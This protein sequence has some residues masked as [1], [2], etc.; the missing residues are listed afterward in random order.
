MQYARG[1]A[2]TLKGITDYT[3]KSPNNAD[4]TLAVKRK[5]GELGTTYGFSTCASGRELKHDAEWLYDLVWYKCNHDNNDDARRLTEIPLVLESEWLRDF[6]QIRYDFE[7][8]LLANS[9]IKVMVFWNLNAF[10]GLKD[11]IQQYANGVHSVYILAC[12]EGPGFKIQTIESDQRM[13]KEI[14]LV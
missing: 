8:L 1:V 5:L 3:V 4:W 11:G 6:I 10:E 2:Q 9:P 13:V 12:Y 7:K 14:S